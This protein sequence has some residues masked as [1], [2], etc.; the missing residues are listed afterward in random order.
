MICNTLTVVLVTFNNLKDFEKSY[1]SLFEVYELIDEIIVIDS[2]TNLNIKKYIK[3]LVGAQKIN[4]AFEPAQGIYHAMN[5]ALSLAKKNNLIWYLNPGDVLINASEFLKLYE[6]LINSESV[7][8]FGQARKI[9]NDNI[10]IFPIDVGLSFSA[11]EISMGKVSISHQAMICNVAAILEIGGF[12]EKYQICA[13]LKVQSLMT[14]KSQPVWI[15]E[16][17][18]EID[19]SGVSHKRIFKTLIETTNIR[20]NTDSVP[21]ISVI[22]AFAKF[23]FLK[24]K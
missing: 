24:I 5:T 11:A 8:G 9:I 4:Y 1:E 16:P 15:L 2:S 13:D 22:L 21:K 18:V 20:W 3:A 19:I 6:K 10:E 12:D 14:M 17:I 23:L 7:W